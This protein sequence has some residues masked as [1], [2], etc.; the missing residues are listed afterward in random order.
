M[1]LNESDLP[2]YHGDRSIV[3][4]TLVLGRL[5][6]VL[7]QRVRAP[8]DSL[9]KP[10]H[11]RHRIT[12]LAWNIR[13]GATLSFLTFDSWLT[14][15]LL[16]HVVGLLGI[17]CNKPT[18]LTYTIARSLVSRPGLGIIVYSLSLDSFTRFFFLL[19]TFG[20]S[21]L[22]SPVVYWVSTL[23]NPPAR[24]GTT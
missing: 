12:L 24:I 16:L 13:Q 3:L 17:H 18:S 22:L 21:S 8:P 19:S 11:C 23:T 6:L 14:I 2:S 20:S 7:R 1:L 10:H 15:L 4:M 5:A 9:S